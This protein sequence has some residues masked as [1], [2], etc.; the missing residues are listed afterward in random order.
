MNQS[1]RIYQFLLSQPDGWEFTS[2]D[3]RAALP[4]TTQG[5]ASGALNKF[6]HVG[7]ITP[8]AKVPRKGRA[9]LLP[10]L[11]RLTNKAAPV[12]TRNAQAPGGAPGRHWKARQQDLPLQPKS[13]AERILDIALEVEGLRPLSSYTTEELWQELRRRKAHIQAA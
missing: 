4:G 8:I 13:L 6:A 7:L 1:T 11:Y 3:I 10:Y 2:L 5:G 9:G 12:V